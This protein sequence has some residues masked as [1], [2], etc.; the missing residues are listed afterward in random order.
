[1]KQ[2]AEIGRL[3]LRVE[4]DVWRA[5]Y[6]MPGTMDGALH[7]GSVSIGLVQDPKRRDQ[8]VAFM[9]DVVADLIERATGTRPVWPHGPEPAPEHER[10]GSA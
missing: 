5:Y 1:M 7:L 8:F 3:A 4:G 6:A 9:R 10:A 2:F